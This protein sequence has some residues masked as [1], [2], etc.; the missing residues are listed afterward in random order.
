MINLPHPLNRPNQSEAYQAMMMNSDAKFITLKL[1]TGSGK[2][3]LAAQCATEGN[4]TLALV[5]T[6]SLQYQYAGPYQFANLMGK[7]NY[8]CQQLG[9]MAD[10]FDEGKQITADICAVP[11]EM[12]G[13]CNLQCPYPLARQ[14]FVD[15]IAGVTNYTKFVTDRGIVHTTEYQ[16]GFNPEYLFLDEAHQLSDIVVNFA[17]STYSWKSKWL[18]EHCQPILID[19]DDINLPTAMAQRE[20]L[21]IA[22][23]WLGDLL[24]S[25]KARPAI[26][27]SKKGDLKKWLWWKRLKDKVDITLEAMRIEP[28]CWFVHGDEWGLTIK[29][30]TG[31]FHFRSTFDKADKIIMMSATIQKLDILSLGITE[32]DYLAFPSSFPPQDRPVH[33]LKTPRITWKS[34]KQDIEQQHKIIASVFQSNSDYWNGLVHYPSK[35]K[36]WDGAEL[37]ARYTRRPVWTPDKSMSTDE[38]WANWVEFE[39]N[40]TGA[41]CCAWAFDTGV[42]GKNIN[43]NI[44]AGVP[45][46]NFGDR[47]EKA[48]FDYSPKEARIRVA[49][50]IE[51]QMGRNRRGFNEHYGPDANKFNGIADGKWTR[52]K[53]AFDRDFIRSVV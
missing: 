34:S 11:K 24:D 31:R 4:K 19:V 43:I 26:H 41:I 46:P 1:P 14:E 3:A 28:D 27:P 20:A 25:L 29:P 12:K 32:F 47:Y 48:R 37:L 52:L 6:K 30:L 42:D 33:D 53:S 23:R 7:G 22:Y 2:T 39:A 5:L 35:A 16:Q 50:T 8:D 49:N 51:Q 18:L 45:Y 10:M 36:T 21:D 40:N 15:S 13:E 17:G 38:A 44:T 9:Q